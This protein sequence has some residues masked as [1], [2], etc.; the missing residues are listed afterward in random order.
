MIPNHLSSHA[1]IH[2]SIPG[3]AGEP[4][5]VLRDAQGVV[6]RGQGQGRRGL[7]GVQEVAGVAGQDG[8]LAALR[9]FSH[10]REPCG[11]ISTPPLRGTR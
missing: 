4:G 10:H 8:A 9:T 7:T 3:E 1:A 6:H 5:A 11:G 2:L